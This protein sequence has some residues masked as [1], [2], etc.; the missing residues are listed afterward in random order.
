LPILAVAGCGGGLPN[1]HLLRFD[2][3]QAKG[4]HNSYH[5][6]PD[7]LFD[8]SHAYEHAPL[9]VQLAEQ[10]VRQL[11]LDLHRSKDGHFEVFHLPGGVDSNT[12]C[13]RFTGCLELIAA[14]SDA[15]RDHF[16]VLVWLEPKDLELD[17]ADGAYQT[18][19]GDYGGL[20]A[21]IR[22]VFARERL[23]TPEDV[24][25]GYATLPD[26]IRAEGWPALADVRGRFLFALL[27]DEEHRG[28]YVA[29][30]LGL[31]FVDSSS[32]SDPLAALFKVNDGTSREAQDVVARGFVVTSNVDGVADPDDQNAARVAGTLASGVHFSSTDLPAPAGDRSYWADIPLRCNPVSAPAACRDVD[33]E[34]LGR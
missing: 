10:G 33:L 17:W 27:D 26:A 22:S 21:E 25:R 13:R 9:D 11:E 29:S 24:R 34:R 19:V 28:A 18:F 6:M 1:D 20:E 31:L 32:T 15:N 5:Q 4:T 30:G 23:V 7:E 8:A 3:A 12:T 14:W 16:P 2:H